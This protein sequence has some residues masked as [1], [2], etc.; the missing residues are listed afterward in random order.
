MALPVA[1]YRKFRKNPLAGKVIARIKLE[2]GSDVEPF[3]LHLPIPELLAGAWMACRE[4][5]LVGRVPREAKEAV[6][7]AV[8]AINRCPYC[9]DA[10]SIMILGIS[11]RDYSGAIAEGRL[12]GIEDEG[13]RRAAAWGAAT[14]TPGSKQ[15]LAPPFPPE[16]APEFIGTAVFFHYINRMVTVLL[17]ESPL[18]LHR[19]VMKSMSMRLAARFFRKSILL[20][21]ASGASLDLLPS[22]PLPE[23]LS[24]AEPSSAVAGGYAAFS[25]AVEQA[26][27]KSL[28]EEVR[29]AILPLL[30]EWD[31]KD[32]FPPRVWAGD[33]VERF[34]GCDRAAA[35]LALL[36]ALAP[37]SVTRQ[38]IDDY[39]RCCPGEDRLLGVL[40]WSSFSAARRIGRWMA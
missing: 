10:H 13:I 5:L 16:E 9:V 3:T 39:A 17:G 28:A 31:G 34:A 32:P 29:M 19:T 7:A 11:G 36:T 15:L 22:A 14:R 40:A 20:R 24:W 6:A 12:D 25:R 37:Y 30:E 8:S 27:R 26:G 35:R 38:D 2:F 4:S 18:P 23:D 21:K 1:S 33:I